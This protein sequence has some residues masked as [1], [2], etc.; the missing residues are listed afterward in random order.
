MTTT[1]N[2]SQPTNTTNNLH[3]LIDAGGAGDVR[4]DPATIKALRQGVEVGRRIDLIEIDGVSIPLALRET[5]QGTDVQILGEV[6]REVDRR[7]AGPRRRTGTVQLGSVESL[8]AYVNHFKA[9]DDSDAVGFAPAEPPGVTVIFDYHASGSASDE[10]AAW[11]DDRVSFA[12]K[13]SRQW[14]LWTENE[15]ED[16]A[17]NQVA[18]GD[19][20]EANQ[21]DLAS[22]EG[23]ATSVEMI[24]MARNLVVNR[25]VKHQ[26]EFNKTTG[27]KVLIVKDEHDSATSTVI[28]PKFA[29]SI[30]IFEGDDKLYP[31]EALLHMSMESG[32]PEFTYTLQNKELCLEHALKSLRERVAEGCKIPVFVGVAPAPAAR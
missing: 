14:D 22:R 9:G 15:G 32:R 30:P 19:F 2:T 23:F 25:G 10:G 28:P 31:V 13:L 18:F 29:L 3:T 6:L 16:G 5:G 24:A 12:C 4:S 7:Q 17:K 27:A 26:F 21:V 20:I 11:C 1:E 8:I